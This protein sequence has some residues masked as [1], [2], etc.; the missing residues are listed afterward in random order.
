MEIGF[1]NLVS[2]RV[3]LSSAALGRRMVW[4]KNLAKYLTRL[5][6]KKNLPVKIIGISRF[7]IVSNLT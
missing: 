3:N 5:L 6:R 4:Q 2:V 1:K 7:L